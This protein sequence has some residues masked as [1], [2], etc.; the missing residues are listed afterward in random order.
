MRFLIKW[1]TRSRAAKFCECFEVWASKL[2]G[3][4]T[5]HFLVSQDT[6]D[7]DAM[8]VY[9]YFRKNGWNV[10]LNTLF[11]YRFNP[12]ILVT[13]IEGAAKTKIEAINYG[14]HKEL[15]FDILISA[16]DDMW[17]QAEGFDDI[18]AQLMKRH[19]PAL[20]GALNFWDGSPRKDGLCTMSLMGVEHFRR[21]GYIYHP[22][23]ISLFA[24]DDYQGASQALGKLI[25]PEGWGVGQKCLI[26]H[27]HPVWEP[28]GAKFYDPLMRRNEATAL[29][30]IDRATF[31]AR[32][33]R[34]FDLGVTGGN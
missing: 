7:P 28:G 2:S 5:T 9:R 20:D 33:A 1:P 11:S 13:L 17:P 26:Q 19:W 6:D 31:L 3:L 24:D 27:K 4:H 29:Y 10:G 34:N 16:A 18:V 30:N 21:F 15:D 22:S 8:E 32:K 12:R 25:V 14:L 23:Y